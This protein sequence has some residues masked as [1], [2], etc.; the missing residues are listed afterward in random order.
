MSQP[1][2]QQESIITNFLIGHLQQDQ[3]YKIQ[4]QGMDVFLVQRLQHCGF[5][6]VT[7][8]T[9]RYGNK[10]GLVSAA[11]QCHVLLAAL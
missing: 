9:H 4:Q 11:W 1:L 6:H 3:S 8:D 10:P 5:H 7:G 2:F